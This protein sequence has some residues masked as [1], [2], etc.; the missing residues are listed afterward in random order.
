VLT[1]L[2]KPQRENYSSEL[3]AI[4]DKLSPVDKLRLYDTGEVPNRLNNDER[5][6]V[7]ASINEIKNEYKNVPYYEGR[8]GA[9]AREMKSILID[10]AQNHDFKT[11]SP[12]AVISEIRHFIKKVSE[13]DF[14]RQEM[15]DGYHDQELFLDTILDEYATIVDR[16]VRECLG[17]YDTKQW[18]DFIKKY[19]INLSS[20]L[21]KEKMKKSNYGWL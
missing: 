18:S 14:L 16:E 9:S 6:L 19:I 8:T 21:K 20:L 12:L 13:Y 5:K 10:A 11:L 17:L 3:G 1:R 4:L 2:K 7:R 15:L